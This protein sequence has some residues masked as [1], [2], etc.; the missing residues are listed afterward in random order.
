M[1]LQPWFVLFG[2]GDVMRKFVLTAVLVLMASG[3]QASS[4]QLT[5]GT[6]DDPI[7]SIEGG[8][9]TYSGPNLEPGAEDR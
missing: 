2:K 1:N 3:A 5:D 4:Y 8:N 7:Q 9:H 6:V